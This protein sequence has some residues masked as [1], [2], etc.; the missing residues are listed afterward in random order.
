[1]LS[2][3]NKKPNSTGW[4]QY[5]RKRQGLIQGQTANLVEIDLVRRGVKMPML[6]PWPDAPYAYLIARK[7]KVPYCTVRPAHYRMPLPPLPVP[8]LKSDADIIVP[9]QPLVDAIYARSRYH[10]TLDYHR[11]LTPPLGDADRAWLQQQLSP[12]KNG[13]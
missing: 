8:L 1:V 11:E 12:A 13:S 5:L 2:P 10:R 9:M 3:S 6:D 4:A 7:G